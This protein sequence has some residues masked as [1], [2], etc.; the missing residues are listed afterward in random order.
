MIHPFIPQVVFSPTSH[1]S[2]GIKFPHVN[3]KK[4]SDGV[5]KWQT[6]IDS[7]EVA[8]HSK[9]KLSNIEK[10]NYLLSYL[11]GEAWS[12]V[13]SCSYVKVTGIF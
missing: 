12:D 8:Q 7:F 13:D 2:H 9:S 4:F 3:I 5:T 11:T 6:F 10:M 1:Q